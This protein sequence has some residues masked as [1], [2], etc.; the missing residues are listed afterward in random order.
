MQAAATAL[1]TGTGDISHAVE[2]GEFA[3]VWVHLAADASCS[4]YPDWRCLRATSKQR[5]RFL[6]LLFPLIFTE[7]LFAHV[8]FRQRTPLHLSAEKGHLDI[9]RLLLQ[10]NADK[11]AKHSGDFSRPFSC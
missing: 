1:I 11:E 6:P 3:L 5:K 9:C 10:N 7:P 4:G 2:R 8:I